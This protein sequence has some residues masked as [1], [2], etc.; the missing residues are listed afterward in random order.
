M[1]L[2]HKEL[3][4]F[5]PRQQLLSQWRECCLIYKLLIERGTPNHILVNAVTNYPIEHFLKYSDLVI[6]EFERRGYNIRRCALLDAVN[7]YV[8]FD[9]KLD[10]YDLFVGWH[11]YVYLRECLYNL[12][13]KARAGGISNVEW[14]VIQENFGGNPRTHL[15]W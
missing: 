12:E 4:R 3:I 9:N 14:A 2:W 13:E 8:M 11:D 1:R 7:D 10:I 15:W 6:S 5:L